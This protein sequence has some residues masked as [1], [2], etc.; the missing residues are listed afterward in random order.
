MF[1]FDVIL[2]DIGGV[3]LTNGWDRQERV[4]VESRFGLDRAAFEARHNE[5]YNDWEAGRTT[6]ESY[7]QSTIFYEQ[8]SFTPQEVQE[9][10]FGSSLLLPDGALGILQ[11]LVA[12]DKCMLGALNNEPRETNEHRF[13]SFGLNQ[14]FSVAISSCYVHLRKPDAEIYQHALDLLRKPA[15]RILFIDDRIENAQAAMQ[16]G[17]QA[18]HFTGADKLRSDLAA[19]GVELA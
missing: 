14:Y 8:R 6:M 1:P 3:L 13:N 5:V 16:Q 18:L 2:F 7:L 9:G 19:K 4:L 15:N 10:I 12:S 11:Q 17:M